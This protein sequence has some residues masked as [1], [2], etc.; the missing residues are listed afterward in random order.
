MTHMETF[1]MNW[2]E[3]P[4]LVA[5]KQKCDNASDA[6]RKEMEEYKKA[7]MEEMEELH[8][9]RVELRAQK[10]TPHLSGSG[11]PLP[12]QPDDR[13]GGGRRAGES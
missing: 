4:E 10:G 9:E 13:G 7:H 12:D 11:T 1:R 2:T 6:A 5:E 8:K 3:S